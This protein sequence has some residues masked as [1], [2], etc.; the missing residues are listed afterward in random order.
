MT[1]FF[2]QKFGYPANLVPPAGPDGGKLTPWHGW[3]SYGYVY[4]LDRN[5]AE[6][7]IKSENEEL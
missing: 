2:F 6:A 7:Q 5:A 3:N 4:L 1:P